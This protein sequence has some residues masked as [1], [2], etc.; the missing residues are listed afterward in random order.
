MITNAVSNIDSAF[1]STRTI[2]Q[3]INVTVIK[4]IVS[5]Q[6]EPAER[7]AHIGTNCHCLVRIY[8]FEASNRAVVIASSLWSNQGNYEIWETYN[9]LIHSV[10]T[11]FPQLKQRLPNI[12]WIAHSGQFSYPLSW[13]ETF[14]HD[15]FDAIKISF[16]ENNRARISADEVQIGGEQVAELINELPLEPA[17]F[18]L[19]QLGHDNGWDGIVDE[20]QIKACWE[21]SNGIVN[22]QVRETGLVGW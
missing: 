3:S 8:D 12:D 6:A 14:H 5:W 13:S 19:R 22:G 17:V 20:Q 18:V 15:Q 1:C 4:S 9:D 16:D 7:H 2:T 21:L 10:M 11:L